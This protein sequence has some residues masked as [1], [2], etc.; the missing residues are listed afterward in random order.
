MILLY[1]D[2]EKGEGVDLASKYAVR[3][4]PTF[5]MVDHDGAVTDRWAG[6]PG[7]D[8]FIELV[9][10][11][12]ADPR[13]ID[14]KRDAFAAEPT[15][16]LA[17]SLGRH[18]EAVFASQDAVRYYR[19]AMA[20][21]PA[22]A[23]DLRGKVFLAM[24]YGI[25]G[26]DFTA[27]EVVAEG[28]AILASPGVDPSTAITVAAVTRRLADPEQFKPVLRAALAA[29]E[30]ATGDMAE[31]RRDLEV[32]AA[33]L[34]DDDPDRAL[35]LKRATMPDGWRDDPSALNSFAWWC[36]ENDLNLDEAQQLALR[37][38]ELAADDGERANILDTAAEIAFKR[39]D[40]DRAIELQTRAVS[41]AP[42]REGLKKTLERFE[43]HAG[44]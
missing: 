5:A 32:D 10:A 39:G 28:Q 4:Y 14:Q 21:D 36:F 1:N 43:E 41:L 34:L 24:F 6:Y 23:D 44:S 17:L 19:E 2:C 37:G 26:E 30:G 38:V 7:V 18:S 25:R 12:L 42:D 27:D 33:L 13:P 8:G 15:L 20:M 35:T 3:V 22:S 16:A 40:V 31:A 11:A 29:T 9:D